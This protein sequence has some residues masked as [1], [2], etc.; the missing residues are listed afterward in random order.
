MHTRDDAVQRGGPRAP[1]ADVIADKPHPSP[2]DRAFNTD[3]HAKKRRRRWWVLAAVGVLVALV[4]GVP[5][6]FDGHIIPRLNPAGADEAALKRKVAA[7]LPPGSTR[8][9]VE[10]WLKSPG[11][12]YGDILDVKS[13]KAVGVGTR[14]PYSDWLGETGFVSLDFY[15]DDDGKL[16]KTYVRVFIF[17][18]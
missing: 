1:P 18:L 13:D 17:S 7:A 10:A 2:I 11:I 8:T 15:F 6:Y 5:A 3:V 12:P 16:T 14:Q 4:W 9:Q